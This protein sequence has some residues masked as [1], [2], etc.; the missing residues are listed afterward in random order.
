MDGTII[1]QYKFVWLGWLK[2]SDTPCIIISNH[3]MIPLSR[4]SLLD[5][6]KLL[7]VNVVTLVFID[8][9]EG[10]LKLPSSLCKQVQYSAML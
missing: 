2:H 10:N 1:M 6:A 9:L 7:Q 5:L 8:H 3:S 4:N